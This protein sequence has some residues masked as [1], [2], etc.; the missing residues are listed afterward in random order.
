MQISE[1]DELD[2]PVLKD[3]LINMIV[4]EDCALGLS[5]ILT[6]FNHRESALTQQVLEDSRM[7]PYVLYLA[8]LS[9]LWKK[10]GAKTFEISPGPLYA[11]AR[12]LNSKKCLH[13]ELFES[14]LAIAEVEWSDS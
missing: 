9:A 8:S 4:S 3:V 12:A 7:A 10:F 6:E 1:N 13:S 5:L 14:A 11:C 2:W